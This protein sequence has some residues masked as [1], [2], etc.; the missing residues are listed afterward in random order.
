MRPSTASLV[1]RAQLALVDAFAQ[2]LGDG[3]QTP[4]HQFPGD[5]AH[6][7]HKPA[8]GRHLGDAVAHLAGAYHPNGFY[9]HLVLVSSTV[10]IG[11][12][13]VMQLIPHKFFDFTPPL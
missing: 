8:H 4:L 3:L 7:H 10:R 11:A 13:E 6:D 1:L 12:I 9:L 2:D 5:I